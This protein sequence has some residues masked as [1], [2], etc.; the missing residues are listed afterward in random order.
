MNSQGRK[1]NLISNEADALMNAVKENQTPGTVRNSYKLP[2][3]CI[4]VSLW[5]TVEEGKKVDLDNSC[6]AVNSNGDVLLDESAYFGHLTNSNGSINHSGDV[7]NGGKD[8]IIF[9]NLDSVPF[10]VHVLYFLLTVATNE[11][12]LKDLNNTLVKVVDTTS[13]KPLCQYN[14]KLTGDSPSVLLMRITR[15]SENWRVTLVNEMHKTA[16]EFGKLIPEALGQHT[17]PNIVNS[18]KS[19]Q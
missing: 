9:C 6:M 19:Y 1:N 5:W 14:P 13:G 3:S 8:E 4:Q 18:K 12:T 2:S 7:N 10:C 11:K 15:A 16:K 17:T